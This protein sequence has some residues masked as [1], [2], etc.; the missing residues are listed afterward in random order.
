MMCCL[1]TTLAT[2]KN[3]DIYIH[4]N[5][6]Y[7]TFFDQPAADSSITP[8][9]NEGAYQ[10]KTFLAISE[11]ASTVWDVPT[12][13][14]DLYSYGSTRQTTN[15]VNSDFQQLEGTYEAS[16]LRDVNSQGGI[17]GG[18]SMKGKYLLATLRKTSA[19]SFVIL[20]IVSCKYIDSPLTN[21]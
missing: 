21:R 19:S 15:L 12:I 7:N 14:T 5:S 9:F 17:F 20:N 16:I 6:D 11:V 3:G 1:G 4:N 8:V 2:F 13:Q 10:K 18:D